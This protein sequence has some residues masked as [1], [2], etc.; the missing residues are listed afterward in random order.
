MLPFQRLL[1]EFSVLSGAAAVPDLGS[2]ESE[3]V[4]RTALIFLEQRRDWEVLKSWINNNV[5]VWPVA[6]CTFYGREYSRSFV[7]HFCPG[8]PSGIGGT[9]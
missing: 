8:S 4:F 9:L 5:F 1:E 3:N 6:A 7:P 2:L